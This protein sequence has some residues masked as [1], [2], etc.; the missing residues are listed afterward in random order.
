MGLQ[1]R[2]YWKE[3]YQLRAPQE[4]SDLF[5]KSIYT[6]SALKSLFISLS[7]LA[8]FLF[9][10][11]LFPS[12]NKPEVIPGGIILYAD[13]QGHYRGTVLI[14]NVSM[15]FMIDT[16]ATHTTVPTKLAL[17]AGLPLGASFQAQTAGGV[18]TA[19]KTHIDSLKFGTVEIKN[20]EGSVNSYLD[21]VLIGMN[22]LKYFKMATATKTLTL[23]AL[24]NLEEM[25]HIE[26]ALP[27]SLPDQIQ[28]PLSI[29]AQQTTTKW[30]KTVTC[31]G[32]KCKT[33]YEQAK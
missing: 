28:V 31:D 24:T 16:G 13:I 19:Q 33:L 1:D 7:I 8:I 32:L 15:P 20:L 23:V 25:A 9:L 4:N 26:K 12:K 14:N 27:V 10:F 5:N 17:A 29:A 30:K 6:H 18:V 11:N 2:D 3:Q 22:T 21:E